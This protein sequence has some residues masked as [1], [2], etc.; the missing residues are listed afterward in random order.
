MPIKHTWNLRDVSLQAERISVII[1]RISDLMRAFDFDS[2]ELIEID[3]L[4]EQLDTPDVLK[5]ASVALSDSLAEIFPGE[6]FRVCFQ[7]AGTE[8]SRRY[9]L[10]FRKVDEFPKVEEIVR[11]SYLQDNVQLMDIA[12]QVMVLNF[13]QKTSHNIKTNYREM[14]QSVDFL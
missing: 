10:R 9:Y 14:R 11:L 4:V 1:A 3:K 13:L 5:R 8:Q 12:K 2:K 7:K 6:N